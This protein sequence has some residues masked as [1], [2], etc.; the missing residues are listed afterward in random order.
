MSELFLV[1]LM[2]SAALTLMLVLRKNKK[3]QAFRRE[4]QRAFDELRAQNA[5]DREARAKK[6]GAA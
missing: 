5:K 2:V 1:G 3:E 6:G 4:W